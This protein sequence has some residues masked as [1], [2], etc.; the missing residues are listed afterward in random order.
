MKIETT[1]EKRHSYQKVWVFGAYIKYESYNHNGDLVSASVYRPDVLGNAYFRYSGTGCSVEYKSGTISTSYANQIGVYNYKSFAHVDDAEYNGEECMVY[2]DN[3]NISAYYVNSHGFLIGKITD[4]N[5][6][7]KRVD[8]SYDYYSGSKVLM[9][10]F[11]LSKRYAFRCSDERIF[12]DPSSFYARCA[13]S[14]TGAIV[15]V[16]LAAVLSVLVLVF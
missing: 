14:T 3:I 5:Q 2:Y 16:V 1:S 13:A 8:I 9:S 7:D 4:A 15:S 10:D 6:T 12:H 11:T